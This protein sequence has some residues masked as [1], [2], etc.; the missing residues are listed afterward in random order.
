MDLFGEASSTSDGSLSLPSDAREAK[1]DLLPAAEYDRLAPARVPR[2]QWFPGYRDRVPPVS[3]PS[4]PVV[5][6]T[7]KFD[8]RG[9]IKHGHPAQSLDAAKGIHIPNSHSSSI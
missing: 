4:A 3:R 8:L 6:T 7:Y 2:D 1:N 9:E 5:G